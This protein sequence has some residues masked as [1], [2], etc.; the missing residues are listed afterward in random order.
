M[1]KL[2]PGLFVVPSLAPYAVCPAKSRGRKY[3][4]PEHA[5]KTP[6]QRDRDRILYST[7]FRR[8][9]YKT[10]V[11]V[12][13]EGDHFRTRLTHTLETCQISRTLA[14][15]LSLNE[16]LAEAIA[17]GHD[18]GHGPFGH[19]GEWA[20]KEMMAEHGS[21]EH[22]VQCLR[23]VE[24]LEES[25]PGFRGLNLS[26]ETLEGLKKHPERF[27][28]DRSKRYRTLEAEL[29]DLADEIAYCSHDLDDGLRAGLISE[30]QLSEVVL[31]QQ[32]RK[33]IEKKHQT[34]PK[35]KLT[36]LAIRSMLNL[37]VMDLIHCSRKLTADARIA[38]LED[39]QKTRKRLV[40]FS[41][42]MARW[43]L[44]LKKFL[45]KNLYQHYRVVRMTD[46]GQ[47]FLKAIFT[48][49]LDKPK[50]LPPDVVRRGSDEGMPRAVCD[51]VAGMTDRFAVQEYKRLFEPHEIFGSL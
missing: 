15:A 8:L 32:A 35:S 51:Y 26:F 50:L 34:L 48:A 21:F 27:Y 47:R 17:L 37:M 28:R 13:H 24:L 19:A 41:P 9:Q 46:K 3:D 31:W 44:D 2:N 25:Y 43:H 7:A 23:I 20:L 22:N 42:D 30:D 5:I 14:R 11:F 29:V 12:N 40:G 4:E 49:Y 18:L 6:F 36:P 1:K 33:S 10:Q 39:L 38:S 45:M 16:D